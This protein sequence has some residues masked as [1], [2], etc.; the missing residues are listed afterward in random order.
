MRILT[1][2]N[3]EMWRAELA[4]LQGPCR[5]QVQ[6]LLLWHYGPEQV[7]ELHGTG[8]VSAEDRK[9]LRLKHQDARAAGLQGMQTHS[10]LLECPECDCQF[11]YTARPVIVWALEVSALAPAPAPC[12]IPLPLGVQ[13]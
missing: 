5:D 11:A 1:P 3:R 4:S 6:R 2:E 12:N 7:S 10:D 9:R 8:A 13:Q